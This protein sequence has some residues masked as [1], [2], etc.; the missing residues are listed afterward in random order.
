MQ[1]ARENLDDT[2]QQLISYTPNHLFQNPDNL[3]CEPILAP[4]AFYDF[5]VD[6]QLSLKRI[7]SLPSLPAN[8]TKVANR[9]MGKIKADGVVFPTG[10]SHVLLRSPMDIK[11]VDHGKAV[12]EVYKS[13][14]AD[15]VNPVASMLSLHP[16]APWWTSSLKFAQYEFSHTRYPKNYSMHENAGLSFRIN[17]DDESSL[18]AQAAWDTMDKPRR[19]LFEKA[20]GLFP[21]LAVFHFY[22]EGDMQSERGLRDIDKY[23]SQLFNPKSHTFAPGCRPPKTR[24]PL[25][26]D[27]INA[28]W[29]DPVVS[30]NTGSR[31]S[32]RIAARERN[33]CEKRPQWIKVTLP[34]ASPCFKRD[35]AQ[36]FSKSML[37]HAWARAVEVDATFILINCANH[38]RIGYRHRETQTLFISDVIDVPKCA[39][40]SYTKLH[41]GLYLSIIED[42]LERTRLIMEREQQPR[43]TEKGILGPEEICG[44]LKRKRGVEDLSTSAPR[45]RPRTRAALARESLDRLD[46]RKVIEEI[47][48]EI[49]GRRLAL[50]RVQ[51]LH[52]N[53]LTPSC[54][55]ESSRPDSR[56]KNKDYI[57]SPE[58]YFVVTLTSALCDGSTGHAHR[59]ALKFLGQD[60]KPRAYS[61]IVVKL[62][63]EPKAIARLQNEYRVYEHLK[64]SGVKGIPHVFG[65]YHDHEVKAMILV[66]SD[67]GEALWK[68]PLLKSGAMQVSPEERQ[69]FIEVLKSIHAA[70]VRHRDIRIM[71]MAVMDD[72]T[73]SIFDFDMADVAASEASREREMAHLID[74]LDGREL[75][76]EP[77]QTLGTP[78]NSR[79]YDANDAYEYVEVEGVTYEE[80][81]LIRTKPR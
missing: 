20:A 73:V 52:Y 26:P 80:A 67:V 55:W 14:M 56:P 25:P 22:S 36:G 5:H 75:P 9:A 57:C 50:L 13:I 11:H 3:S 10:G 43:Q 30:S 74:L 59:A 41:L 19:E 47:D 32:S 37:L 18:P 33:D 61:N 12:S 64:A 39:D 31:Q 40:P 35:G 49:Q 53:S 28:A 70:G 2:I 63:T 54:F 62:A 6:D 69:D 24:S 76:W 7:A 72:G 78:D 45:K 29:G 15:Y 46:S 38:E 16:H 51:Y 44:K 66:M 8:L 48:E 77:Q 1:V 79:P 17:P 34:Q 42:V 81:V 23:V 4:F 58:D 71:N 65:I 68:R 60:G 21:Q 27:A